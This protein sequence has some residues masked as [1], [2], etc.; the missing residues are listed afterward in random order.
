MT[1][2][3]YTSP[4]ESVMLGIADRLDGGAVLPDFRMEVREL[5]ERD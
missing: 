1:I 4:S 3:V 2:R 5:F